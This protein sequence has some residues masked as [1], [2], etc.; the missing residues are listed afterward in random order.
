MNT[1][2]L[3][4]VVSC[5]HKLTQLTSA[6]SDSAIKLYFGSTGNLRLLNSLNPDQALIEL[7]KV[8]KF[9][10][11]KTSLNV[12]FVKVISVEEE[13]LFNWISANYFMSTLKQ[14]QDNTSQ[15]VST[16]GILNMGTENTVFS[17]QINTTS[18]NKKSNTVKLFGNNYTVE[19][20]GSMCFGSNQAHLRLLLSLIDTNPLLT[21]ISNPCMPL[22]SVLI[23]NGTKAKTNP[24]HQGS[25]ISQIKDIN[26]TFVGKSN[27]EECEKS[28]K[29]SLIDNS[30]CASKFK[31]CLN[32]PKSSPPDHIN[33]K[34]LS[35]YSEELVN[36]HFT[37][38]MLSQVTE[39]KF[40]N[41]TRFSC[42][43]NFEELTNMTDTKD[44]NQVCFHM[45]Y[46][47]LSI[48]EGYKMSGNWSNINFTPLYLS[49]PWTFGFML[50]VTNST[51]IEPLSSSH[52]QIHFYWYF[53]ALGIILCILSIH[54][55]LLSLKQARVD[56]REVYEPIQQQA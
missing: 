2:D 16:Y 27:F 52:F 44:I 46:N 45:V 1:S 56:N 53:L 18:D 31:F 55:L 20:V 51:Q 3:N 38:A 42:N 28:V 6:L 12:T 33:Y 8:E 15:P 50:N 29:S 43:L 4:S 25:L 37:P 5:V 11:N 40:L 22:N 36:F 13:S 19:S 21:T 39:E 34:A 54:C 41:Q 9:L 48:I 49:Q 7:K 32:K 23:L 17:Y 14:K 30:Y 35:G 47:Y 26:Y 24:C 10:T